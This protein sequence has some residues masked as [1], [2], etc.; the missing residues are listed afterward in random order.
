MSLTGATNGLTRVDKIH[1]NYD[2]R[3]IYSQLFLK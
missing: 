3:K 1:M 2:L